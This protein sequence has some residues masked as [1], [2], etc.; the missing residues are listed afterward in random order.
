MNV[1]HTVDV[2][3]ERLDRLIASETGKSSM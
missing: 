1:D 2:L 3:M